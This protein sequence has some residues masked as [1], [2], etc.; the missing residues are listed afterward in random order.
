MNFS[1]FNRCILILQA[2]RAEEQGALGLLLFSDPADYAPVGSDFVYPHSYFMPPS[3]VPL[4]TT[5]LI[6]GDP[7][8]PFYPATGK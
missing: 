6:D 1:Y 2:Q 4:G 5:K 7:L 3:A 8:T